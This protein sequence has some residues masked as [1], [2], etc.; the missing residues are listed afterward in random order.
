LNQN[1]QK[2]T[3]SFS[4][5]SRRKHFFLKKEAK[6]FVHWQAGLAADYISAGY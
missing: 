5:K 6:T 2:A 3:G 4:K 1:E